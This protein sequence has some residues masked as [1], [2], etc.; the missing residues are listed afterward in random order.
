M[1]SPNRCSGPKAP[2]QRSS[3][4]T[5]KSGRSLSLVERGSK[6]SS[7]YG[8]AGFLDG[9]Y[10]LL[11]A[12]PALVVGDLDGALLDVSERTLHPGEPVQ[13]ALDGRLAV[14]AAHAC[15]LEPCLGHHLS[16]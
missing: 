5:R 2:W 16:L 7:G 12:H 11:V 4:P 14:A 10:E 8:V 3:A 9:L 1:G 6:P 13:L 15:N